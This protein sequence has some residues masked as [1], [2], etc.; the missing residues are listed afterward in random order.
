[1]GESGGGVV[2]KWW[3]GAGKFCFTPILHKIFTLQAFCNIG[4]Y[5]DKDR[6]QNYVSFVFKILESF[7]GF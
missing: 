7:K 5:S 6:F 1:M 3:V 2:S 4:V